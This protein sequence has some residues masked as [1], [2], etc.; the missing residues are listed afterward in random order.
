M[1][2]DHDRLLLGW[3]GMMSE[4]ELHHIRMRLHDGQ[5]HKAA[6]GE[7]RVQLPVGLE[8]L[9]DGDVVL[10]PDEEVQATLRL[11]FEKFRELGS[12]AGVVRYLRAAE[13]KLPTRPHRGPEP[14]PV[15]WVPAKVSGVLN[16]LQNPAYAGVYAWGR[17][18]AEPTRRKAEVPTVS[19]WRSQPVAN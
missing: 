5:R 19:S 16:I 11:V 12:A 2:L 9:R 7:L 4:A 13:L 14:C 18:K 10:N 1:R 17:S 6:R 15:V 3:A 8:R